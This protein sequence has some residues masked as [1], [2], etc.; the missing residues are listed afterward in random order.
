[1]LTWIAIGRPWSFAFGENK[2]SG[3]ENGPPF[4]VEKADLMDEVSYGGCFDYV[5]SLGAVYPLKM[6]GMQQMGHVLRRL[7]R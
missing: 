7:K 3:R 2:A 6:P 1:M 4:H 5:A